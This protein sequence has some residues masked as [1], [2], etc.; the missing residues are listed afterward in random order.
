MPIILFL[1]TSV[2]LT[3]LDPGVRVALI[4][5]KRILFRKRKVAVARPV[6]RK[7]RLRRAAVG[8]RAVYYKQIICERKT[9]F[10]SFP[11]G[12]KGE[13]KRQ[14]TGKSRDRKGESTSAPYFNFSISI[15]LG[16]RRREGRESGQKPLI[17]RYFLNK[18]NLKMAQNTLGSAGFVAGRLAGWLGGWV[19]GLDGFRALW[20]TNAL[21]CPDQFVIDI[22]SIVLDVV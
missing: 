3:V 16:G 22:T 8:I 4:V 11:R 21:D 10:S 1:F 19:A 9:S 15:N 18:K 14:F 2:E 13:C 17:S 7:I 20:S 5:S 6:K 12:N